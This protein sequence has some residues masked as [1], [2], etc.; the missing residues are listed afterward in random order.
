M[1]KV[2]LI[3]ASILFLFPAKMRAQESLVAQDDFF[4]WQDRVTQLAH[5]AIDG[6]KGALH[7][8]FLM[9]TQTDGAM[10]ETIGE[11]CLDVQKKQPKLF[12]KVLKKESR[13]VRDSVLWQMDDAR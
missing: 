7:I 11:A 3:L 13:E 2:L 4:E 1:R 6:D 10:V 5:Q 9:S 12:K 8:L